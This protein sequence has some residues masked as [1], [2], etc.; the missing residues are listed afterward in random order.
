MPANAFRGPS[1]PDIDRAAYS[2]ALL[3]ND[4]QRLPQR[5]AAED[6]AIQ[7]E[8]QGFNDNQMANARG[9]LANMFS[10]A[11]QSGDP[12]I[13]ARQLVSTPDFQAAGK[14][15]GLPIDQFTPDGDPEQ[16]R[17]RMTDWARALGANSGSQAPAGLVEFDALTQG[18]PP[19]DVD[20]A[21]RIKLGLN[22]RAGQGRVTM[23]NNVPTWTGIGDD[24]QPFAIPLSSLQSEADSAG[25][26]KRAEA[27]GS[28]RGQAQADAEA[29]AP[30]VAERQRQQIAKI[31]TV[32]TTIDRALSGVNW[33]TVGAAGAISRALPGTPAYD[34]NQTLLTIKANIGFDTLQQM[35]E[36][37][38]TGGALGQVAVQELN[39]LQAAR[40]SLEQAQSAEQIRENLTS[41]KRH[42]QNWRSVVQQSQ[43]ST[44]GL[45]N[46]IPGSS[47]VQRITSDQ[48]YDALP[49]GALFMGPDGV[50]RRKP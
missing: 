18:M 44:G 14:L 4:V 1:L 8:Q 15:L 41:I 13:A 21:R 3:R 49:S 24:G 33:G 9:I 46:I 23:V 37:S 2:N 27:L 48:E 34:L 22:S 12:I 43:N 7:M 47:G 17:S 31:D 16:M 39:A 19:Q 29:N 11:A 30:K 25:T 28:G 26:I 20:Q 42:Y 36:A 10:A 32:I 45:P 50:E 35:R 5:N 40:G 38:P 6:Q